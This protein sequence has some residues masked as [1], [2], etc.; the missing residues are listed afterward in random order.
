M[1]GAPGKP[2]L[3]FF[4]NR[5]DERLPQFLLIHKKDHVKCLSQF[6]EVTVIHEDCD[7]Q[8]VCDTYQ[9]DL[10]LFESGVNHVT[11][12]RPHIS[13]VNSCPKIP[14]LGLHNADAFCNARAGFLSDMDHW[15]IDT[16]FSI[17][18]TAAE[19]TPEI[20]ENL[21]IWPNFVDPEIYHDYGEWKSIPVLLTGNTTAPYPW[22]RKIGR[23]IAERYP[24][25]NCPHPG[26][27]ANRAVVQFMIGEHYA[28]TINASSI[29][30][31]CGT[32][33]K[34]V[35]RKHFEIPACRACLVTEQSPG[36]EA[37]GFV[38]MQ[39][40]VFV[41][42]HNA[43]EKLEY[44]FENP[45]ELK[46]ITEAGYQLVISNHTMKQR[47]QI[48]QWFRLQSN[49][50]P[51]HKIVQTNPFGQLI[52][53]PRSD[54]QRH[55]H[56]YGNG[57]H[58]ALLREGDKKL[59]KGNYE[60][61]ENLFLKC[62]N[63]MPWMPE[64]R[65]R[66]A[67]CSLYRGNAKRASSFIESLITFILV[68]Y[69]AVDPD[70][71]EWAY[72]IIA[73]LC[74]EKTDEAYTRAVEYPWLHHPE[75]DRA[76]W[77]ARTLK[78][79]SKVE[80]LAAGNASTQRHTIHRLPD[81]GFREW[82]EQIC[83][84]LRACGNAHLAKKL[85]SCVTVEVVSHW[86]AIGTATQNGV[87]IEQERCTYEGS[88]REAADVIGRSSTPV[89]LERQVIFRNIKSRI[90]HTGSSI[91]HVLEAKYGYFL[92]YRVS[93]MRNDEFYQTIHSL[94]REEEFRTALL[95][96]ALAGKGSTEAFLTGALA[97]PNKPSVFCVKGSKTHWF[98]FKSRHPSNTAIKWYDL[99]ASS[100]QISGQLKQIVERIKCDNHIESFD[101]VLIDSST[102]R[103]PLVICGEL[104]REV[105][106]ANFVLLEDINH[107]GSQ[108][109]YFQ[110][111]REPQYTLV[112]E[113]PGLRDGYGVFKRTDSRKNFAPV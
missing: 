33:A 13:N 104:E 88:S 53:V 96:G 92:P 38:D 17:A 80:T 54:V 89:C 34:E 64:P 108:E 28:R 91:L 79:G 9:P 52:A 8:K 47:D 61:A 70:P 106:A 72:S 63:H 100:K 23:L 11:C 101:V 84:M 32:I 74:M 10:V 62:T 42:E 111:L 82:T 6:F 81:R 109:T 65:L 110:L 58:L 29:V 85:E 35:I 43:V 107:L 66:I 93:A 69:K 39:N 94:T 71:V 48:L 46:R 14:K 26:Y 1:S 27:E 113:N 99:A 36:L 68:D 30:P 97:N 50:P 83:S 56:V 7:Y 12:R 67:L 105:S 22:R 77:I 103:D 57:M 4:Q 24:A 37:A 51:N 15:G 18:T 78:S 25:M 45:E 59:W 49:L 76:R 90:R 40:C 20:A 5:Y 86:E 55:L 102:F 21:F 95:V 87:F 19:H 75:L 73:M 112:A 60:E 16:F 98:G 2:K 41:D 3:V 31:A 44:L